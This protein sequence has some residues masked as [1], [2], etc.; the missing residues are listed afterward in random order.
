VDRLED[1]G[2]DPSLIYFSEDLTEKEIED[3]MERLAGGGKNF[4]SDSS[5]RE[6]A[7]KL[8]DLKRGIYLSK[9]GY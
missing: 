6:L 3:G 1:M 7:Q 9:T 5:L 8:I 2:I 4:R